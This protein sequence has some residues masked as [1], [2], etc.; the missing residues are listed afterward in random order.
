MEIQALRSVHEKVV[1][2]IDNDETAGQIAC[3][4]KP[5]YLL[6]L[7]GVNGIYTDIHREDS[8]VK[9]IT[10]SDPDELGE[11]ID[12]YVGYCEGASRRGANGAAAKLKYI[13]EPAKLGTTVFIANSRYG[14]KAVLEGNAPATKIY[15]SK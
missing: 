6:I 14:I 12:Y 10:A 5:R 1:E 2:C 13:K 11:K 9:E 7:T 8:L 15:L 3:L 4:V